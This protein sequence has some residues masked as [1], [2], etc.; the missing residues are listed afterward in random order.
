MS[1]A[2]NIDHGHPKYVP[3]KV[4]FLMG[5]QGSH[6]MH[7]SMD[8]MRIYMTMGIPSMPRRQKFPLCMGDPW[9][10]ESAPQTASQ[11]SRFSAADALDQQTDHAAVV[12]IVHINTS[13]LC[14]V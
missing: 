13:V 3:P 5:N 9:A 4:P 6:L 11:P 2:E 14:F 12:T 10:H 1:N 7:G 8:P